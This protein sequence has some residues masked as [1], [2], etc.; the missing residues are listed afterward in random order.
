M[1]TGA[2]AAPVLFLCHFSLIDQQVSLIKIPDFSSLGTREPLALPLSTYFSPSGHAR[3]SCV[4]APLLF[5][6]ERA[7]E[8][9]LRYRSPIFSPSGHARHSCVTAPPLFFP[10]RACETFLRYS[11]PIIF[12]QA[13]TQ[14]TLAL[15]LPYYFS[16]SGH[17]RHS[18]VTAPLLFF[19]SGHARPSCVTAPLL[20]SSKRARDSK[21][22]LTPSTYLLPPSLPNHTKKSI[23]KPEPAPG[24]SPIL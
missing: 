21:F 10:K 13:G 5:F 23:Q 18:C 17:A 14:D 9:L 15:P 24:C 20:F 16:P 2:A 3:T 8:T 19:P 4:T 12:L 6:P 11:S 7:C 22:T 1:G